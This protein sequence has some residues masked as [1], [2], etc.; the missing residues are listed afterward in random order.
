M[1]MLVVWVVGAV[2]GALTSQWIFSRPVERFFSRSRHKRGV[3]ASA[4]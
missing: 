3:H 4:R 2:L 1:T